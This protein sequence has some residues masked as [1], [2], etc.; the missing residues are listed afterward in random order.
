M[1]TLFPLVRTEKSQHVGTIS[2]HV[3]REKRE[4]VLP[5][6]PQY[7]TE[8]EVTMAIATGTFKGFAPAAYTAAK[9]Y[10]RALK[11]ATKR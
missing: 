2:K 1:S 11:T 8:S 3:S 7:A 5:T 4:I 9:D 10:Q 6:A